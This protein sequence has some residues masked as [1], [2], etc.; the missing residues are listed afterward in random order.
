M[1]VACEV[2]P[3]RWRCHVVETD[4]EMETQQ[5]PEQRRTQ[6]D[7][8]RA[9]VDMRQV[10]V[11]RKMV[12]LTLQRRAL[13]EHVSTEPRQAELQ[14]EQLGALAQQWLTLDLQFKALER[15][16]QAITERRMRER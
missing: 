11:A 10:A 16:Q 15:Q 2:A 8:R 3:M 9:E 6:D 13:E 12:E 14:A 5:I 7:R 4:V 1:H